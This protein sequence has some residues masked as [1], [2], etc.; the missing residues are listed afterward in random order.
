[1]YLNI[2]EPHQFHRGVCSKPG[3]EGHARVFE[4]SIVPAI[5]QLVLMVL[6]WFSFYYDVLPTKME[7]SLLITSTIK[8]Y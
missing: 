2:H 1:M 6:F 5:F 4:V 3:G 8:A 7:T